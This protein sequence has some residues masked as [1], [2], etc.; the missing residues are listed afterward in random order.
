MTGLAVISAMLCMVL[1][2]PAR[3]AGIGRLVRKAKATR[4]APDRWRV[5]FAG[6][7]AG[8]ILGVLV[9]PLAAV[10]AVAM[11]GCTAAWVITARRAQKRALRSTRV[12][13]RAA[14]V[15]ESLLALGHL[16]GQAVMMAAEECPLLE[17]VASAVRLGGDP[18]EVMRHL[19]RRPGQAGL[20]EVERA[21][22]VSSVSG[23]SMHES[24]ERVRQNL[25]EAA[26]TAT[27][28]AGELAASRATGQI[29]ALL[30]CIGLGLAFVIGS[31]PLGFLTGGLLGRGC[32]LAGVG[33]ACVGVMWSEIL[34]R[35]ASGLDGTGGSWTQKPPT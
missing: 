24:L 28:V 35:R 17:P 11:I 29:L 22:R 26:D 23:A 8:V 16:P 31:D 25:E 13:L 4:E 7:G 5:C 6:C 20:A 12:V 2:V 3:G 18:W 14:Q 30:P 32:L 1:L 10:S 27:V 21:W 33:L 19:S 9:R 34:A 15:V